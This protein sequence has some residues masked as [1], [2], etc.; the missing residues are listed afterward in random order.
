MVVNAILQELKL[1]R[2]TLELYTAPDGLFVPNAT[3]R[4]FSKSVDIAPGDVVFD[5]G[6]GVGALAVWAALHPC[7]EVHAVDPVEGHCE[8]A[9]RNAEMHGVDRK[10]RVYQGSLFAPL[11]P[12]LKANV[13]IGDVSGIADGPG[14]ALGWYSAEV[15]TGGGDGTEVI[16]ELLRQAPG[17]LATGGKLYFPVAVGLSDDEKI[18]TVAR[19]CFGS[20]R[21]TVDVW[22]PLSDQEYETV[23]ACLPADLLARVRQRGSRMAWN[24]HIYEASRPQRPGRPSAHSQDFKRR[25]R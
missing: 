15:P 1:R 22:F 19:E 25:P 10:V 14:K 3:T 16:V 23:A 4:L 21:Q 12:A 18:M 8:L 17:R 7:R 24:G 9:A 13:I 5:I 20:L 2:H 6:T 11:P